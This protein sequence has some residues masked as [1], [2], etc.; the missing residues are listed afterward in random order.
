LRQRAS[1]WRG[2]AQFGLDP[3]EVFL[4]TK[5]WISDYGYAETLHGFGQPCNPPPQ[6]W[7]LTIG[8]TGAWRAALH[9]TTCPPG[10]PFLT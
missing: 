4:E 10:K 8:C 3:G 1:G 9:R 2:G 5:V 6:Y 7:T